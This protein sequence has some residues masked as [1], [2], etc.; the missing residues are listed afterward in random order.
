M[1]TPT[2][3]SLTTLVVA[4]LASP[5]AVTDASG[6]ATVTV[7]T[8]IT[9]NCTRDVSA[10]LNAFL[11]DVADGSTVNFPAGACY[12][13]DRTVLVSGK[14]G[15]VLAGNGARLQRLTPTPNDL[16]YPNSNPILRL[17]RLSQ[18]RISDFQIGGINMRSDVANH[19]EYGTYY[20]RWE[21][22]HGIAISG[23][24]GLTVERVTVDGAYGDGIFVG[25]DD[26]W[27]YRR[28]DGI[29][30]LDITV[31]HNGR[32]GIALTRGTNILVDR[33]N[34]T[35]RRA[36]V[37]LEPAASTHVL[38]NV[39]IRNSRF[40][41]HLLAFASSGA[42]VVN[43]VNIHDNLVTH[44]GTPFVH[45]GSS[46][47]LPRYNWQIA[48]NTVTWTLS[49]SSPGVR[50]MNMHNVMVRGN[51]LTF[52]SARLM[53]GVRVMNGTAD[54]NVNCNWFRSA[55]AAVGKDASSSFSALANT[56][57]ATAPTCAS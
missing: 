12:R 26:K 37:D 39:E 35:S 43:N 51:K 57:G 15:L 3:L 45:A 10:E 52:S 50:L 46:S 42:G 34:I 17:G 7:P 27:S 54:V 11:A 29:R 19:P 16:S 21:F 32:Q 56:V 24:V 33:A 6:A 14:T 44:T 23:G 20:Q 1:R 28:S 31:K 48:N 41:S 2:V 53:Q 4:A 55:A 25:G 49:S 9:T 36:G 30:L 47:G 8:S 38:T 22:D 5:M 40:N 13:V 18:S